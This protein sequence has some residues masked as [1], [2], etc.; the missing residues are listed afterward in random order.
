MRMMSQEQ[1]LAIIIVMK[2]IFLIISF[3][4]LI[5]LGLS[6]CSSADFGFRQT[7]EKY[8]KAVIEFY[9]TGSSADLINVATQTE[10]RKIS[11]KFDNMRAEGKSMEAELNSISFKEITRSS[12]N[13]ATVK[14]TENWSYRIFNK[15]EEPN[16]KFEKVNYDVTYNFTNNKESKNKTSGDWLVDAVTI[17]AENKE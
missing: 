9:K 14:T 2:K 4:A 6:G 10:Q 15:N 3:N 7:V 12:K 8:N 1:F 11:E 5:L 16:G 13:I 17:T